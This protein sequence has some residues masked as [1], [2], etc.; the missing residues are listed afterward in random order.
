MPT[1]SRHQ[2]EPEESAVTELE[3]ALYAP[4]VSRSR[5]N[6]GRARRLHSLTALSL[7]TS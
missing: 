7:P 4:T 6:V 5:R 3:D 1:L 2:A